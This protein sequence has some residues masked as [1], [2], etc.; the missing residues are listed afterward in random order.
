MLPGLENRPERNSV[1][2]SLAP[3]NHKFRYFTP[4]FPLILENLGV[5]YT[6]K[7]TLVKGIFEE[8]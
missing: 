2:G 6:S 7:P 3:S 5:Q 8:L 4:V 1:G